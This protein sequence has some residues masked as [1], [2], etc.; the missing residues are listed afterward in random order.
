MSLNNPTA[1]ATVTENAFSNKRLGQKVVQ[2]NPKGDFH[3]GWKVEEYVNGKIDEERTL[4]LTGNLLPFQPLETGGEQ[5]LNKDFYAGN[6][7]PVVHVMGS[8]ENDVMFKGR[9]YDKRYANQEDRGIAFELQKRFTDMRKR[10]NL[11]KF[12]LGEMEWFGFISVTNFNIKTLADIDYEISILVVSNEEPSQALI[13]EDRGEVPNSLNSELSQKLVALQAEIDAEPAGYPVPLRTTTELERNRM[14]DAINSVTQFV[15]QI[16]NGVE[17]IERNIN[18]ITGTIKLA[19][20]RIIAFQEKLAQI[21]VQSPFIFGQGVLRANI[22]RSYIN[23]QINTTNG[24][25]TTLR[26]MELLFEKI[27]QTVPLARH[28]VT[29]SDTLQKISVRYYNDVQSWE[30]IYKHNNLTTTQLVVGAVIE[31]PR[32]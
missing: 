10:G 16:E 15:N 17:Q 32:P 27:R 18:R 13:I 30:K 12:S 6:S 26:N 21:E 14:Y 4:I 25:G 3:D 29:E 24:V 8:S 20:I 31:I 23:R 9:F 7:E 11:V 2:Y 22:Y 19:Q 5:K 28:L 1:Q